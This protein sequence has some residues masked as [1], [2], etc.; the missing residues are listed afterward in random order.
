MNRTGQSH[1]NTL[2]PITSKIA[3]FNP[4]RKRYPKNKNQ[5]HVWTPI[6]NPSIPRRWRGGS[7]AAPDYPSP[8]PG[9]GETACVQ[10]DSVHQDVPSS[11]CATTPVETAASTVDANPDLGVAWTGIRTPIFC[12]YARY[13]WGDRWCNA[14]SSS[15]W[16]PPIAWVISI[17]SIRRKRRRLNLLTTFNPATLPPSSLPTTEQRRSNHSMQNTDRSKQR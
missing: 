9:T 4:L 17:P 11:E 12:G 15:F 7:I 13:Y 10:H 5:L 1:I 16:I 3:N 2:L 14:I 8:Q 6:P